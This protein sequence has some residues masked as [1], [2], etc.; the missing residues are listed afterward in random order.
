MPNTIIIIIHFWCTQ[1][2][3]EII[4][5]SVHYL[6]TTKICISNIF[7]TYYQY[8]DILPTYGKV[9]YMLYRQKLF[10]PHN[11]ELFVYMLN[12]HKVFVHTKSGQLVQ[13]LYG[14]KRYIRTTYGQVFYMVYGHNVFI[15]TTYLQAVYMLYGRNLFSRK[16]QT[17]FPYVVWRTTFPLC[18]W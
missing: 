16:I 5:N 1:N 9:V 4:L 12:E 17:N 3:S 15:H 18:I 6:D 13:M 11:N 7:D 10:C 8:I 14:Q 2:W